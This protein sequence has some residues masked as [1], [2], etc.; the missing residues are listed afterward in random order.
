MGS[1]EEITWAVEDKHGDWWLVSGSEFPEKRLE[2][3]MKVSRDKIKEKSMEAIPER[4]IFIFLA[5]VLGM[6][7]AINLLLLYGKTLV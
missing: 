1:K 7:L 4:M 6:S 3:S 2:K 5:L